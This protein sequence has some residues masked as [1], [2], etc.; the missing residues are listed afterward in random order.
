MPAIHD[1]S[2]IVIDNS[3]DTIL[4]RDYDSL[5]D[6]SNDGI[7]EEILNMEA[8]IQDLCRKEFLIFLWMH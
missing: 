2:V 1:N 7:K 8:G 5:I 4:L 3:K 6:L